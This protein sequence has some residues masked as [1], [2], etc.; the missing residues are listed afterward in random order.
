MSALSTIS[1]L[2]VVSDVT[3]AIMYLEGRKEGRK[4]GEGRPMKGRRDGRKDGRKVKE[5]R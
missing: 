2:N 4:E 1:L 5:G 3:I